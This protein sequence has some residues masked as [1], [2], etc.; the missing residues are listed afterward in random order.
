MKFTH[1]INCMGPYGLWWYEE[2]KIPYTIK[3]MNNKFTNFQDHE[4]KVYE[5]WYGGRIDVSFGNGYPHELELPIMSGESYARF[6]RWLSSFTSD[7]IKSFDELRKIFEE[8]DDYKL[9]LF[10]EI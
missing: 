8:S 3:M 4:K 9:M 7:D 10:E 5:Q 6:S 1:N 2:N